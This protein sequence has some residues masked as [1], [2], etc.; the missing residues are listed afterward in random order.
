[1]HRLFLILLLIFITNT[2]IAAVFVVTSNADSGPG[3]LREALTKAAANGSAEKDYINFNLPGTGE[4]GR[5][6]T[7]TSKL[8]NISS[9]LII[10]GTTQ[11]GAA[12]GVSDAKIIL[13]PDKQK[14]NFNAFTLIDVDGFE[15]YGFYIRDFISNQ[16]TYYY[17]NGESQAANSILY[18]E[19]SKNIQIGAPTKGNVFTNDIYIL[20][21]AYSSSKIESFY[22]AGIE[23][24][25]LYANFIGIEPDGKSNRQNLFN[26]IMIDL[27]GCKGIIDIGGDDVSQRN[28]FGYGN[29]YIQ[30]TA[31]GPVNGFESTINIKNNYFNYDVNGQPLVN[32]YSDAPIY[33]FWFTTG[34]YYTNYPNPFTYNIINNKIQFPLQIRMFDKVT[35]DITY[36]GNQE[37]NGIG[38]VDPYEKRIIMATEGNFLMGGD[39]PGQ[40]NIIYGCQVTSGGFKST[41]LDHTKIYCLGSDAWVY[42]SGEEAMKAA[43]KINIT[44]V[45]ASSVSGTATPLSKV[46]LFWDDDCQYCQPQTYFSTVFADASGNW[47]YD[48]SIQKGVIATATLNG[49]TSLFTSSAQLVGSTLMHAS[50][51]ENNGS[52]TKPVFENA[53][54]YIWKNENG[55]IISNDPELKNL[56]PGKYTVT[57][58]NGSCSKD[59][60]YQILDATPQ[61]IADQVHIV[62]PSCGTNTGSITYL[63]LNSTNYNIIQSDYDAY[64]YKWVDANGKVRSTGI[65]LTSVEAGTYQLEVTYKNS[66]PVI[67]G[68]ITLKNTT[69]PAIDDSK[70]DITSTACGQSTGSIKNI[71]VTGGSGTRHFTWK[72]NQQQEVAYTRDLTNQPAGKYTLQVTDDTQCGAIFSKEIEILEVNGITLTEPSSPATNTS[73]NKSNGTIIGITTTGA[74]KFEWRD[75]S[76]NKTVGTNADL[77]DVPAGSYQLTVSN[78]FCSKTS[79]TY[80]ILE[81][82]GTVFPTTY[83]VAHIDAC[84][85]VADGAL[86]INEDALIKSVRWVNSAGV[87]VGIHDGVT[88]LAA[89]SYQLYLTDQNGCESY[90]NTYQVAQ[91]PE[92]TVADR[93]QTNNETCG[94]KNGYVNNVTIT[95]GQPP[96]TYKWLNSDGTQIG[97]TNSISN[98]AAGNYTLNVV[99]SRCGDVDI[100]YTIQNIPQDLPAPSVSDLQVCSPGDALFFVNNAAANSVYRLYDQLNS[101]SPLAE[102]T[103]GSLRI[104][105]ASNRSFFVSR[106]NGTCESPRSEVKVSV[107]LSTINIANTFT[108]NGDGHNDYWKISGIENYPQAVVQIFNRNGQKLFESKGYA[109]PFNGSYNGKP[110]PSGTYFY[111][112]NLNKN[113][114]LLSGSLTIIR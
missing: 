13:Q 44:N 68:P 103:G 88:G 54:G 82:P 63:Y 97:S 34:P 29:S 11:P 113:C 65:D 27:T 87:S 24:L 94:L 106:V 110:L 98:L 22:P 19:S 2:C 91:L 55:D 100:P 8:P 96:Y 112:I 60:T 75:I 72:N 5:A 32:I 99:D 15:L 84:Y 78:A 92:Y 49:F 83:T 56:A 62:Q 23:T 40:G 30:Q 3:T 108:P 80:Q 12:F 28:Y 33:M 35:G 6:I 89:G 51:G 77:K 66:C 86:Q 53:G 20:K 45:A 74:T 17:L 64:Q 43:P 9:N 58:L 38:P 41:I 76:N 101:V 18:V 109:Q 7:I 114:N 4:V 73:C 67:Y 61:I 46:Q 107:G 37:L 93:G 42:V 69:G 36:Q 59:Y 104:A 85:G 48:G 57:A 21:T 70:P 47:R 79:K 71:L 25:K 39:K 16:F 31:N 105:V 52:I 50:C 1:M 102:Q 95:G 14:N 81:T 90:Y 10:D 26:T 111:I